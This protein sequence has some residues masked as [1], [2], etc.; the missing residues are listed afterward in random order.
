MHR[1]GWEHHKLSVDMEQDNLADLLARYKKEK[2][3][4]T[5][6]CAEYVN[7]LGGL[8]LEEKRDYEFRCQLQEEARGMVATKI[9]EMLTKE[10]KSQEA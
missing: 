9:A 4:Y 8:T 2:A 1:T 3:M 6:L 7:K 10:S 5:N